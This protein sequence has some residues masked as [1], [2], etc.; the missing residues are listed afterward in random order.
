MIYFY[1]RGLSI[2]YS[3]LLNWSKSTCLG[4]L[5]CWRRVGGFFLHYSSVG[6]NI[7]L[8]SSVVKP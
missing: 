5:S 6:L 4:S 1:L 3:F 2:S 8:I 7:A